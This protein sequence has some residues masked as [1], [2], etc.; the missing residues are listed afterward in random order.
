MM[1][2][3]AYL[4]RVGYCGPLQ[5]SLETLRNLH[6]AHATTIPFENLDVLLGRPISLDLDALEGKLVIDRRGGYCFEHNT[7]FAAVLEALG[8]RVSRLAAR[9]RFGSTAI[10][11]LSHMLLT[12]V[13]E[14]KPW[15]VDVGFGGEGLLYPIR[16]RAIEESRQFASAFRVRHDGDCH[17]LQ[18]L[19]PDGWFDLYAFTEETWYPIDFVVANHFTS[20]YPHSPFVQS[21]IVQRQSRDTRLTL[22]GREL[23]EES[24]GLK[25]I[26]LLPDD[27][28]LLAT[29][30]D[31]FDLHFPPGTRFISQTAS[32]IPSQ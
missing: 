27:A 2:L 25:N 14:D 4:A 22:R 30:A 26:T 29:L 5:P 10:R 6:L 3:E 9:V 7:L 32:E 13:L 19:H 23:T 31:R 24:L 1:N 18:S 20:T 16:L 11:P 8:F 21:L 17:V 28:A 12:V 15:L